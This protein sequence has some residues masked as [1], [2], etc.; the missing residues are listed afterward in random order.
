MESPIAAGSLALGS[1]PARHARYRP[2]HTAVILPG[3]MPGERVEAGDLLTLMYTSGTTGLPK[4][5]QHTHF[6]LTPTPI[7]KRTATRRCH[8]APPP[9]RAFA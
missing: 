8:R 4:G 3:R 9:A 2:H 6:I 5:I 7:G 1:L